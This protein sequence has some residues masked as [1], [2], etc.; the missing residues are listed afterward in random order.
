MAGL[1][2]ISE[3]LLNKKKVDKP[4][5]KVDYLKYILTPETR[6]ELNLPQEAVVPYKAREPVKPP[7]KDE[8]PKDP[9][10]TKPF[11]PA[12]Q[13]SNGMSLFDSVGKKIQ[14]KMAE[15]SPEKKA[16]E[17]NVPLAQVKKEAKKSA[18]V[19][20]SK[21]KPKAIPEDM[22][23]RAPKE[24]PFK[25]T[26]E[27]ITKLLQNIGPKDQPLRMPPQSSIEKPQDF[28]DVA[29]SKQ[30]SIPPTVPKDIPPV[31][32]AL[33]KLMTGNSTEAAKSDGTPAVDIVRPELKLPE[34]EKAAQRGPASVW[35]LVANLLPALA[36]VAFGGAEGLARTA[37]IGVKGLDKIQADEDAAMAAEGASIKDR[38]K[39]LNDVAMKKFEVDSESYRELVKA[40]LKMDADIKEAK[41]KAEVE[42]ARQKFELV[43]QDVIGK[44]QMQKEQYSQGEQTRRE[45]LKMG[46]NKDIT[47]MGI[48]G[49]KEIE[50][51]KSAGQ[52]EIKAMDIAGQENVANINQ[53]GLSTREL[54]K[55]KSDLAI[56]EKQLEVDERDLD[57]K[58]KKGAN[59][60]E[61]AKLRLK[62]D[63]RRNEIASERNKI[64]GTKGNQSDLVTRRVVEENAGRAAEKV[65]DNYFKT[66]EQLETAKSAIK[67]GN[68]QEIKTL[69]SQL[70]KLGGDSGNI[71]VAE[72]DQQLQK[73]FNAQLSDIMA[74]FGKFKDG[75]I[76]KEQQSLLLQKLDRIDDI[77]QMGLKLK[78]S[79][80][81]KRYK[82]GVAANTAASDI[83]KG[84][85]ENIVKKA[86]PDISNKKPEE[87][88]DEELDSLLLGQ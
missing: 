10:E 16:P 86:K 24:S 30:E 81:S 78:F 25:K 20:I 21:M 22:T 51:I 5:E 26:E 47:L 53:S 7:L 58:I 46:S 12:L 57:R 45:Q 19:D 18:S 37:P 8:Y 75:K 49:N 80:L 38:N 65:S 39:L 52:K 62:M 44:Q 27:D 55:I 85:E 9:N 70:A 60:N 68:Y 34:M 14:E 61:I 2:T 74:Y 43:K 67:A 71:A 33:S 13:R 79:N 40:K 4:E 41:S 42:D 76:P 88:T 87:M 66:Y 31:E 64:L 69:L 36:G 56:K 73:T 11:D 50:G 23:I 77:K 15:K 59:E 63:Q 35:S 82:T 54:A 6:K 17:K 29:P 72:Q 48:Q 84:Y 3:Y 83:I 28:L 32:D 1:N